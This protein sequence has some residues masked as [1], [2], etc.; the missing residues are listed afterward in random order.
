MTWKCRP[1]T[2]SSGLPLSHSQGPC[3]EESY[4]G[5]SPTTLLRLPC[6]KTVSQLLLRGGRQAASRNVLGRAQS[7]QHLCPEATMHVQL[8]AARKLRQDWLLWH[9]AGGDSGSGWLLRGIYEDQTFFLF[10]VLWGRIVL[11]Q[12]MQTV[13]ALIIQSC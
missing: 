11:C 3:E 7:S 1:H 2:I 12:E 9:L 4:I 8:S 6:I 13:D 5:K 10:L